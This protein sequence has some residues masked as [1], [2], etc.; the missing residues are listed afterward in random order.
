MQSLNIEEYIS[1]IPLGIQL[2]YYDLFK[3]KTI[4]Y[5]EL[6]YGV[7][8]RQYYRIYNKKQTTHPIIFFI[9][10]GGW[11]HGSPKVIAAIGKFFYKQGYTVVLPA[12]RLVP[13][14][15]FPTQI[16]DVTMAFKHMMR[17]LGIE[18]ANQKIIVMGFSAGG[19]LG[20][21]LVFDERRHKQHHI[22]PKCIK[23]FISL[24]GVLDFT[25]CETRYTKTLI[26]RYLGTEERENILS[27]TALIPKSPQV[28]VLCVHGQRDRFIAR[29]NAISFNEK[30]KEQGGSSALY[31]VQGK[32]H[33]DLMTLLMG[34][35]KWG[36]APILNFIER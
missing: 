1:R 6:H 14:Y 7:Y 17:Y 4:N 22:D 8:K 27:P 36:A 32:H 29:E 13:E 23:G 19:E 18:N 10:G 11:W 16:E 3:E 24:A 25:K 9:H 15:I 30:V 20:A 5:E 2:M 34:K 12:Y 35:G 28:P 21:R 33:S 31:I 26:K